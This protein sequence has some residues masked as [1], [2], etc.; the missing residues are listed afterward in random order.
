M[1]TRNYRSA[2]A[3][4]LL[5]ATPFFPFAQEEVNIWYFGNGAGLDF[6]SGTPVSLTDGAVVVAGGVA[7]VADTNGALLFYTDGFS[8]FNRNH[9]IMPNGS[10]TIISGQVGQ[11]VV[12]V[13][14]PGSDSLYYMFIWD[15]YSIKYSLIDLSLDGGLGDIVSGT[16][17]TFLFSQASQKLLAV[18]HCNR[19]DFWFITHKWNSDQFYAYPITSTGIGPPVVSATGTVHQEDGDGVY[20][21]VI[22][23]LKSSSDGKQLASVIFNSNTS[24]AIELFDFD[25]SLGTVSNGVV[26]DAL[27][28]GALGVS[29]SPDQ[30][31]LYVTTFNGQNLYQYDLLD[32]DIAGSRTFIYNF[33]LFLGGLQ[34]A[35]D[36]KIYVSH[37]DDPYLGVINDPDSLGLACN[38]ADSGI[39][40]NL[41]QSVFGLP[42][43]I[44][45]YFNTAAELTA[46]FTYDSAFAEMTASFNDSSQGNPLTWFWNFGDGNTNTI[47]NPIHT[48][49]NP[50]T[51]FVCLTVSDGRRTYTLCDSVSIICQVPD[52]SFGFTT[53]TF[54][55]SFSDSSLNATSWNWD[56]GD[57]NT[58]TIQNPTHVYANPGIFNVC[59][60]VSNDCNLDSICDSLTILGTGINRYPITVDRLKVYPNPVRTFA[61]VVT[62]QN[63]KI[64]KAILRVYDVY[65]HQVRKTENITAQAIIIDA[66]EL[67]TG[68]YFYTLVDQNK[69]IGS[70]KFIVE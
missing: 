48:Y 66:K 38:Y 11:D 53:S 54:T 35:P 8:V 59:L 57:G 65:G 36:G 52:A 19:E 26:I 3:M 32:T 44:E 24:G 55:V 27:N 18:H 39:Y 12:I 49:Q 30:T 68:M 28:E 40:L 43:I 69:I 15:L 20:E 23:Y 41:E 37:K 13:P 67:T 17:N 25:N 7:T 64:E 1:I 47:Q 22:G 14:K 2:I 46:F 34:L 16:K 61:T 60:T 31:K 9:A 42:N 10:G 29:F 50:G 33:P 62:D 5:V 70:G 56:F 4:L 58:D 63:L 6:N 45:T 51:F 21:E